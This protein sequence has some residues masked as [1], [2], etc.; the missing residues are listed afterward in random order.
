MTINH[1]KHAVTVRNFNDKFNNNAADIDEGRRALTVIDYSTHIYRHGPV[2]SVPVHLLGA[3]VVRQSRELAFLEL[4]VSLFCE[5]F[6]FL[7]R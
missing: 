7:V 3:V 6:G 4:L 5:A 2:L 1:S